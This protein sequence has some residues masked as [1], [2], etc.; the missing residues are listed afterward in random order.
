MVVVCGLK[1][2]AEQPLS[3]KAANGSTTPINKVLIECNLKFDIQTSQS[4]V[5]VGSSAQDLSR[6]FI[7]FMILT[8]CSFLFD[9][10]KNN[11]NR[12]I[13]YVEIFRKFKNFL[14]NE[15]FNCSPKISINCEE[16]SFRSD[17]MG[18]EL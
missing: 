3:W 5:F 16:Q 12:V 1:L 8:L 7:Y 9:R 6:D 10:L 11:R 15:M 13:I 17:L 14:K 4:K 18:S 2:V